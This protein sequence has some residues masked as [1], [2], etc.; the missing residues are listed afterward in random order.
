LIVRVLAPHIGELLST[1]PQLT[2][3]TETLSLYE[4][5]FSALEERVATLL[6][7]QRGIEHFPEPTDFVHHKAE[8]EGNHGE[9]FSGNSRI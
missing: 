5:R 7:L 1:L 4:E 8:H 3:V 2:L 9:D 6:A